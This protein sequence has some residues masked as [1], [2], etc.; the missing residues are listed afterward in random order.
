MDES[1]VK[2][3]ISGALK[4][5]IQTH[6]PITHERLFSAVKRVYGALKPYRKEIERL[7][8]LLAEERAG[9]PL[10]R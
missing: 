2:R 1:Q 10:W 9:C 5:T 3:D 8:L 6:G 7:R 4:S